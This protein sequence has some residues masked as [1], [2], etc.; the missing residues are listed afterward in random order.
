MTKGE[1]ESGGSGGKSGG[2]P[3]TSNDDYLFPPKHLVITTEGMEKRWTLWLQQFTFWADATD[4]DKN[5]DRKKANKF[6]TIIGPDAIEIYNEFELTEAEKLNCEVIV[7]KFT[8]R[9]SSTSSVTF[10]RYLFH[11]IRQKERERAV[12]FFARVKSQAT[13]CKFG[14]MKNEF[15]R[16]QIVI[17]MRDK[18]V[19]QNLFQDQALT[20]EKAQNSC[21]ISEATK[22]QIQQLHK[23]EQMLSAAVDQVKLTPSEKTEKSKKPYDCKRCGTKHVFRNCPAFKKKCPKC[24]RFGHIESRCK[25]T[26]GVDEV[27]EDYNTSSEEE[28]MHE[29][30]VDSL[31][32][33]KKSSDWT[34]FIDV[35]GSNVEMKLDTGAQCNVLPLS[36][37]KK[38][39]L[40]LTNS[41]TKNLVSYSNHRIKVVG[42]V[43]QECLVRGVRNSLL[44]KVI[45][46]DVMPILGR[47]SCAS[48][49]LILRVESIADDDVFNG[50]GCLKGYEYE[51]DLVAGSSFDVKPPRRI[52]YAIKSD[53][54]AELQK[55]V[56][57]GVIYKQEEATPA[58][59]PMIVVKKQ[60][61]I[62]LCMDPTG[63]NEKIMRRHFPLKQ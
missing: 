5:T 38:L 60:G 45:D 34:E 56:D 33:T 37:C 42:E 18:A 8:D 40:K 58:V 26:R 10:Q 24:R 62:R 27:Y 43:E 49:G 30:R 9:F 17:G 1:G 6:M 46:R 48:T 21:K 11:E 14:L 4:F 25:V 55:M 51:L 3:G 31:C 39:A 19:Q 15:V 22:E 36:I 44:F 52:P 41:R 20:L 12:E 7:E 32:K 47:D 57:A 16:D 29:L 2:G 61:K 23:D 13:K 63:L 59:S 54:K 53:V 35:V 50:L 28:M